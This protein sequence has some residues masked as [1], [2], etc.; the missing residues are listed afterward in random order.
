MAQLL[1]TSC[2]LINNC[3][4]LKEFVFL[5][6]E[7]VTYKE[8]LLWIKKTD[9]ITYEFLIVWSTSEKILDISVSTAY[10]AAYR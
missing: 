5:N 10:R 9:T 2:Y 4:T 8:P 1:P 6:S 3:I 7:Q